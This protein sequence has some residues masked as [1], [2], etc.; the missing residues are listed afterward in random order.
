MDQTNVENGN[1]VEALL[2][3]KRINT[4]V[5]NCKDQMGKKVSP[6]GI[7]LGKDN[8][9]FCIIDGKL[10]QVIPSHLQKPLKRVIS[11][12]EADGLVSSNLNEITVETNSFAMEEGTL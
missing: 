5:T 11:S 10:V 2:Y 12:L 6:E 3:K 7:I 4:F 9:E 1:T 8:S